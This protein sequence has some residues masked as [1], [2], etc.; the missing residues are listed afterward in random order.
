M[1]FGS[2]KRVEKNGNA[3]K[4][5]IADE[6]KRNREISSDVALFA[7]ELQ[8]SFG[9]WKFFLLD[10]TKNVFVSPFVNFSSPLR[11][12]KIL[13]CPSSNAAAMILLLETK[14]PLLSN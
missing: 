9:K 2:R 11:N 7:T 14:A 13:L 3:V 12:W 1:D 5:R 10:I 8:R 4:N 6:K